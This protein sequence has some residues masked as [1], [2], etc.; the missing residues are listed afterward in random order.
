LISDAVMEDK[1]V[2]VS[3]SGT[4]ASVE[5]PTDERAHIISRLEQNDWNKSKT[6]RQLKMTYQGLH[7]KMKRLGITRSESSQVQ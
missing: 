4:E 1:I 2:P 6:A 3:L 5:S 7:K